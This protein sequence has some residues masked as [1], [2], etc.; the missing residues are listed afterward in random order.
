L[1][2][3]D[4]AGGGSLKSGKFSFEWKWTVVRL[5]EDCGL[6]T[7][8]EAM[9]QAEALNFPLIVPF[10]STILGLIL[11]HPMGLCRLRR[12][13][14]APARILRRARFCIL[15]CGASGFAGCPS[16]RDRPRNVV[17]NPS[18]FNPREGI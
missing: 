9:A 2:A 6:S 15:V 7:A 13:V 17:S 4:I 12:A 16:F 3:I 8:Q 5:P 11:L 18:K 14:V 10:A 1:A